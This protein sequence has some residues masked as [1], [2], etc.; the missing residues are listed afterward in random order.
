L[1]SPAGCASLLVNDPAQGKHRMPR[2][3]ALAAALFGALAF[4]APASA[5]VIYSEAVSGDLPAANPLTVLPVLALSAGTNTVL[6]SVALS[7]AFQIPNDFDAF[8]FTVPAGNTLAAISVS[9]ALRAEGG[10]VVTAAAFRLNSLVADIPSV[11]ATDQSLF[12][13]SLP[14]SAER[15]TF[16]FNGLRGILNQGDF[17]IAD[18]AL[19]LTVRGDEPTAVAGPGALWALLVGLA[20]LGLV[21]RRA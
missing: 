12:A 16:A 21:R 3:T 20:G 10:G 15:G 6:G 9:L 1:W 11:Q 7:S 14:L 2:P 17:R 19:T 13:A 18:Y 4:A 5:A 8:I